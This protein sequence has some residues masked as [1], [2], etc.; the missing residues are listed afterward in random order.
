MP[1]QQMVQSYISEQFGL[2]WI[3]YRFI[4]KTIKVLHQVMEDSVSGSE[5]TI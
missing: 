4:I 3:R 5:K 1:F 2:K